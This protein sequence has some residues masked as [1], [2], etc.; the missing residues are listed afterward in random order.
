MRLIQW[1]LGYGWKKSEI[2]DKLRALYTA[3]FC[4]DCQNTRTLRVTRTLTA[5][6]RGFDA[7]EGDTA[8]WH[9][10][11]SKVSVLKNLTLISRALLMAK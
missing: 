8:A 9:L 7:A 1:N 5:S 2:P 11:Q 10:R 6:L 3:G 4:P